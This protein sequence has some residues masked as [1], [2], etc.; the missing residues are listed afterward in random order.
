MF[1]ILAFACACTITLR[2][3]QF[4]VQKSCGVHRVRFRFFSLL[5][6]FNKESVKLPLFF[7]FSFSLFFFFFFG[8]S[9]FFFFGLSFFLSFFFSFSV[10]LSLL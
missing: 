9:F 3:A 10:L 7:F 8:L 6:K 4:D 1:L 5:T 2:Q